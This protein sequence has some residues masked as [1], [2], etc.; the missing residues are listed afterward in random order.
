MVGGYTCFNL[1]Q[2][3]W[4]EYSWLAHKVV[5]GDF[6]FHSNL[7]YIYWGLLSKGVVSWVEDVGFS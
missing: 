1:V 7:F 6:S 2:L 5:A 4:Q 3:S